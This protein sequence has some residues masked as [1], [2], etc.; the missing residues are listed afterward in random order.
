MVDSKKELRKLAKALGIKVIINDKVVA[1][2][3]DLEHAKSS[4]VNSHRMQIEDESWYSTLAVLTKFSFPYCE[5]VKNSL[6]NSEQLNKL[7]NYSGAILSIT[8]SYFE[9]DFDEEFINESE[10]VSFYNTVDG[11][12]VSYRMSFYE[13]FNTLGM[14]DYDMEKVF[15]AKFNDDMTC[16]EEI[17]YNKVVEYIKGLSLAD[18]HYVYIKCII[19][20]D[21]K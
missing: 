13:L 6:V 11:S 8:L 16:I 4:A 3:E 2:G 15:D 14:S 20:D 21:I 1:F 12:K 9:D 19:N 17:N 5:Y 7:I 10:A 18:L